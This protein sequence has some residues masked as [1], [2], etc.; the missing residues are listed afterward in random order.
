MNKQT[1][2]NLEVGLASVGIL[3][4]IENLKLPDPSLKQFYED[5]DERII[6]IDDEITEGNTIPVTKAILRWNKEDKD[7]PIEERKPIKI[8]IFSPGGDLYT[9]LALVDIML[10]SKTPV[11]TYNMGIAMSG[12]LLL[13]CSPLSRRTTVN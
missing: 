7:I 4:E 10:L 8:L 6:W 13:I 12:G 2:K 9:T 3:S 1:N 11:Y 5:L